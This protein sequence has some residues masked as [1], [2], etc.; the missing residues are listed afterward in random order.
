MAKADKIMVY[1]V[2]LKHSN[3]L[4]KR[5]VYDNLKSITINMK[6]FSANFWKKAVL[7]IVLSLLVSD[8]EALFFGAGRSTCSSGRQCRYGVCRTNT[9]VFCGAGSKFSNTEL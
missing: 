5:S 2:A 4:P 3:F 9:N 7:L 8:S 6:K 1:S